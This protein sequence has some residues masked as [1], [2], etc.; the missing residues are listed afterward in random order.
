V[1]F[2]IAAWYLGDW[3]TSIQFLM[4]ESYRNMYW[5]M[6]IEIAAY[7]LLAVITLLSYIIIL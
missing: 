4:W 3:L 5:E 2:F 1:I 6:P 7:F